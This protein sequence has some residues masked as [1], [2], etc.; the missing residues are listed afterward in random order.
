MTKRERAAPRCCALDQAQ[1]P[2]RPVAQVELISVELITSVAL[3]LSTMVAATAVSIGIA[4]AEVFSLRAD[5][6][7]SSL[8]IGLMIGLLL[9]GMGGLT[10]LMADSSKGKA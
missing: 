1:S 5:G 8:A 2:E 10:A 7:S 9:F 6:D 3:A 4:R